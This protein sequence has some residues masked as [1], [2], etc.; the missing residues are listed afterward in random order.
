[1]K[2]KLLSFKY[3]VQ[4]TKYKMIAVLFTVMTISSVIAQTKE[5]S[6]ATQSKQASFS[7]KQCLDYALQNQT[8]MKNATLNEAIAQAKVGEVAATGLP[9]INGSVQLSTNDPLRRMFFDPNNPSIRPLIEGFTGGAPLPDSKIMAVPNIFQLTSGG[10]AGVTIS[11]LIFSGSYIV[12]L[13]AAKTY[14]ELSSKATKQTKIDLTESVTKA[15][16]MVLVNEERLKLFE[17]NVERV[18]SLLTQTKVMFDNGM[19]ESI[20]V[21]RI[22][23]TYNNIIT[24]KE[25]FNNLLALSKVLLKYQMSMPLDSAITLTEKIA[26]F[27]VENIPTSTQKLN[28]SDRIEYSLLE[29]Q[30]KLEMLDLKNNKAANLPSLAAFGNVGLFSQSPKFDYFTSS[31]TWYNYGLFG[32]TLNVPIFSGLGRQRK[33]QESQL[34]LKIAENKL[35]NMERTIDLQVKTAEITLKNSLSTLELQNKN[36][37]LANEV[38]RVAKIKYQQGVGTSLEITTA[39]ASLL[40]AQTNYYSA[41]Y[42]ALVAKVDYD[43]ANGTLVK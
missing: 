37:E 33:I 26:D 25:N 31:N 19:V 8:S 13:Q 40:E 43:K 34:S 20:D 17:K 35:T 1:M 21:D 39:E 38:T 41:L 10:D 11:Q 28:Y 6:S 16:Y 30:K 22:Q 12:G 5:N 14:K 36:T 24:Q 32:A 18:D 42:D 3:K 29:S 23:V 9:Q 4:S 2:S 15:Y 7:L 27:K